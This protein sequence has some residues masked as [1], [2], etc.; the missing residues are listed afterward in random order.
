MSN[1]EKG[2]SCKRKKVFLPHTKTL[3]HTPSNLVTADQIIF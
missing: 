1:I 3:F 2:L